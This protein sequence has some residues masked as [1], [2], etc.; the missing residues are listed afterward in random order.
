M[1]TLAALISVAICLN[2]PLYGQLIKDPVAPF[3]RLR[4][5]MKLSEALENILKYPV[6][7]L[8]RDKATGD[9]LLARGH[10]FYGRAET[11]FDISTK[12]NYA[13]AQSDSTLRYVLI[14]YFEA[15]KIPGSPAG[16]RDSLWNRIARRYGA[17]YNE[18][19]TGQLTQREWIIG[20]TTIISNK[21][22]GITRTLVLSLT[23]TKKK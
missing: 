17:S 8:K 12:A 22:D 9:L 16:G 3:E 20:G 13:F 14:S 21:V 2:F 10:F 5:G 7:V 4:W 19:K 6:P 11:L 1:K 23:P 15:D 18:T